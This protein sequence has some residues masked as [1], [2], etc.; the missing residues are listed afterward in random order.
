MVQ[1][2]SNH[3]ITG[4]TRNLMGLG[5]GVLILILDSKTLS[6]KEPRED[7]MHGPFT[8]AMLAHRHL[9]VEATEKRERYVAGI[10]S[11]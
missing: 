2:L 5:H 4:L 9:S 3:I 1:T 11:P 8:Q 10:K 7:A 6:G